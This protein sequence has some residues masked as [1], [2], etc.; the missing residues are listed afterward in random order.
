MHRRDFILLSSLFLISGISGLVYQVVW[1]RN[2]S[3]VI[4]HTTFAVSLVV[5]AFLTGLVLGS[6]IFGRLADRVRNPLRLYALL[7]VGAG[8]LGLGLSLL[9]VD[10]DDICLGLGLPGGGPLAL[11]IALIFVLILPPTVCMGGT[12]PILS[13]FVARDLPRLGHHFG[14]LY[15]LNTLGAAVGSALAGFWLIARLGLLGSAMVAAAINLLVAAGAVG[16]R[17]FMGRAAVIEQRPNTAEV[18]APTAGRR[19]RLWLIAAFALAGFTSIGYEVLWFRVLGLFLRSS[20]YAFTLLMVAFLLG[21]VLGGLAYA[22]WLTKK[23]RDLELFA[24]AEILLALLGLLSMG[25][26]GLT[27]VLEG[28]GARFVFAALIILVPASIIGV[29][30]PLVVQ[31]TTERLKV[32]GRNVGLLYSVNTLGGIVGSALLGFAL[33][34]W[35]GTQACFLLMAGL[36]GLLALGLVLLD[37]AADRRRRL[38][39]AGLVAALFGLVLLFPSGYLMR[40]YGHTPYGQVLSLV[41]G[42]DG[43]LAV[44]EYS[45]EVARRNLDK[46]PRCDE[47]HYRYRQLRFGS[48]SY[49]S[50]IPAAKRYMTTLAHLPMLSHP[51]P[52]NVLVVCFG[53]GITAGSFT[54][55]PDLKSL[56]VVDLNPDVFA[57]AHLFAEDNRRVLEDKRTEVVVDDGRHYLQS[58]ER[59][60]DVISFE[61]PPPSTPGT[62]SLYSL[63]FYRLVKRRLAPGGILAQWIPMQDQPDRLSRMLLRTIVDSFEHVELWVPSRDEAVILASSTPIGLDLGRWSRRMRIP[64]VAASLAEIGFEDA[65]ELMAWRYL[66]ATAIRAYTAGLPSISD[67]RPAVEYFLSWDDGPY[68]W[69]AL[70]AE[71]IDP[72]MGVSGP[73]DPDRLARQRQKARTLWRA[74]SL[75]RQGRHAQARQLVSQTAR[76]GPLDAYQRYLLELE[77]DCLVAGVRRRPTP[78]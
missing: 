70:L 11:R 73:T 3:L 44:V 26:L 34:P 48:V 12:L 38:L 67:D 27:G 43:T 31:M 49:A 16:L 17:R 66:D 63:E 54:L 69:E 1:V 60:F 47:R 2:L 72:Q 42:R 37:P 19:R 56:V 20:V 7:E 25:L 8:V 58:H 76:L 10:L 40:A 36:N 39:T 18:R 74:H 62:V 68:D 29:V 61:P 64:A 71:A 24:G 9:L 33:I 30:F 35:L 52:K 41:E 22:T 50:T 78:R 4:G 53:T 65:T 21:L 28:T 15:S 45:D 23:K 13:R 77:Y 59:Q 14:L 46:P 57:A 6:L 51:D 75:A 55:Y 32:T 5:S